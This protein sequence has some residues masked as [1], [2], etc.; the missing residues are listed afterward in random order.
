VK[1]CVDV[2]YR[3]DEARAACVLF[4]DWA[5]AAPAGEVVAVVRGV[6][7]YVPGQFAQRELPCL[8]AVLGRVEGPLELVVVDGYV[9]LGD[10]GRPGLGAH[11]HEALG[12][13]VPV[14]GVA[15]SRYAG[16]R[17]A[18]P[19]VRGVNGTS[20]LFVTAA[21][22]DAQEAARCVQA[23]HGPY[24]LPTLL[25]RADALCRGGA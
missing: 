22:M 23:M 5:D 24:R 16:S 13:A 3:G 14:V 7:P 11:L 17:W 1:A 21:G 18:V 8:L 6:A 25:K 9:T 19:V 15:K 10:D 12:G 20:P 2:D 4:R